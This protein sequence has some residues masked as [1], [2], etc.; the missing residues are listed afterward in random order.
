M[1][2]ILGIIGYLAIGG[3]LAG[4]FEDMRIDAFAWYLAWPV[5]GFIV[6]LIFM[7]MPFENLGRYMVTK[8][9]QIRNRRHT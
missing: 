7:E 5:F 1:I 6:L 3:F 9:R 4:V 2:Y 8:I